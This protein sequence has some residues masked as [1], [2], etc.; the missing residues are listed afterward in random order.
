MAEP[1]QAENIRTAVAAAE[2]LKLRGLALSDKD[3]IRGIMNMELPARL[4]RDRRGYYVSVAH[5]P[6]AVTEMIKAVK[7]LHPGKKLIYVFSALADKDIPGMLKAV[8]KHGNVFMVLTL[9]KNPR[10]IS[11]EKLKALVVKYRMPHYCE[12]D[13]IKALKLARRIRG[14]GVIVIGGSFYLAGRFV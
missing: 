13:N 3:I 12:P 6:A 14:D 4:A 7:K 2:I 8:K 9:I 1:I 10:A 11:L 5:N